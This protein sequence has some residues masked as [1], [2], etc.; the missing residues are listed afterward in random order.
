M[1]L[2]EHSKQVLL[3]VYFGYQSARCFWWAGDRAMM[4]YCNMFDRDRRARHWTTPGLLSRLFTFD[5][6]DFEQIFRSLE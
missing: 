2:V 6:T 5:L 3:E 4:K 1:G